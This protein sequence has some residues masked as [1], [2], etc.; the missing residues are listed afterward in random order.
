MVEESSAPSFVRLRLAIFAVRGILRSGVAGGQQH[1]EPRWCRS[2]VAVARE[3][4]VGDCHLTNDGGGWNSI[5]Q[6]CS[7]CAAMSGI[8]TRQSH[9]TRLMDGHLLPPLTIRPNDRGGDCLRQRSRLCGCCPRAGSCMISLGT[10]NEHARS[11]ATATWVV[12]VY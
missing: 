2:S 8:C 6:Q 3:D 12:M 5:R 7:C 9:S 11:R 1:S 10:L 4:V